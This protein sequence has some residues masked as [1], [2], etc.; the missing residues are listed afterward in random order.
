MDILQFRSGLFKRLKV[1]D[2]FYE[3]MEI[4]LVEF[5]KESM[6]NLEVL[7]LR[8]EDTETGFYGL[9]RLQSIK[10]VRLSVHFPWYSTKFSE[11]V[12]IRE[13]LKEVP[14]W[15]K[16]ADKKTKLV[17]DKVRE[18]LRIQLDRNKNRPVLKME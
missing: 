9:E 10:E 5:E 8:L 2:L 17:L 16:L 15:R 12:E 14:A 18:K 7:V 3:R 4:K 13:R 11:N 1:L 6:P